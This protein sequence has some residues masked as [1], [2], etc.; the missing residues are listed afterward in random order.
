MSV[1]T[2]RLF[3]IN[4]NGV[5]DHRN[6][7]FPSGAGAGLPQ[8]RGVLA[9]GLEHAGDQQ[10]EGDARVA[11]A[12]PA[13]AQGV[14]QAEPL[15]GVQRQA[16]AADRAGAAVADRVERH[17]GQ[18]GGGVGVE[19]D[20][21]EVRDDAPGLGDQRGIRGQQRRLVGAQVVDER[22]EGGPV[23]LGHGELG[24][25]VEQVVADLLAG[26]HGMREAEG[27]VF[28]AGGLAAASGLDHADV[29]GNQ[30][31]RP[32]REQEAK[33]PNPAR[34]KALQRPRQKLLSY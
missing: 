7:Q 13:A 10:G 5:P 25:E 34:V 9:A 2:L 6:T 16:L 21:F 17:G 28:L 31:G 14:R 12:E 30:C 15:A 4:R 29:H 23:A 33:T 19:V 26:A 11:V 27:V 8:M 22:E 3:A 20:G 32:E 18:V 1:A 24:A